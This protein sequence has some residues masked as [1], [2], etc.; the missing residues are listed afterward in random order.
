[1]QK[2]VWNIKQDLPTLAAEM[3]SRGC[4]NLYFQGLS[5]P[6]LK[7]LTKLAVLVKAS[8]RSWGLGII[9]GILG[10]AKKFCLWLVERGYIMPSAL[11]LATL[12]EWAQQAQSSQK[13]RLQMLMSVLYKLGCIPF[14]IIWKKKSSHTHGQTISEGV[15][16][17]LDEAFEKFDAPIYLI[18]KLHEA[19][20]TRSVELSRIPLNCL[21]QRGRTMRIR[22]PTGK[23]D[24]SLQEQDL[25]KELVSLVEQ[26]Q[27]F[28][29]E[30]FGDSFPWLFSNWHHKL[31]GS[32]PTWPP[33]LIYKEEQLKLPSIKLNKLLAQLIKHNNIRT[34]DG[35][36]VHVT[37]HQFR[38]T[39]GTVAYRMG[40]RTDQIK[41]GLRH[42]NEDM[43]DAY[44]I[45]T[46]QEQEK[47]IKVF[48][49]Q[50][51]KQIV[52]QTDKNQE[53]LR[54]EWQLRQTELGLCLRPNIIQDCE[55]EHICLGCSYAHYTSEHL[56][57]LRKLK[58]SNQQLLT[59]ALKAG[60]SNSRRA[61]SARQ[62]VNI[63]GRII[64]HIEQ[65]EE[66]KISDPSPVPSMQKQ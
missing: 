21:R 8:T 29:R 1:M 15:K 66:G 3:Y 33:S 37:T 47:K 57:K 55:F 19:L 64:T 43:Q 65:V 26:Q 20:A 17:Q 11:K 40:K 42:L 56:P 53:L 41:H 48:V 14:Q 23:Q 10:T 61:H 44:V 54:R 38:R 2:D 12:Q 22:V 62:Q 36:L 45:L 30:Q 59:K 9:P 6:W 27:M 49:N 13:N 63:L 4:T 46:P 50:N 34:Q 24:N 28:I 52:Y 58:E 18:F 25:P 16:Q 5:L 31:Q 32:S 60:H 7:Q 39:Y 35:Q 51:G